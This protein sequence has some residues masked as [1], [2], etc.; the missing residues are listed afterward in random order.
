MITFTHEQK[1]DIAAALMAA[2][3][4]SSFVGS[5]PK[6]ATSVDL[7]PADMTAIKNATWY[8]R[9]KPTIIGDAKWLK[10]A[11]IAGYQKNPDAA[12]HIADTSVK[13]FCFAQMQACQTMSMT[14]MLVD[15]AGIGKTAACKAY[16]ADYENVFYIDC[17]IVS[18]KAAFI[19]ELGKITGAGADGKLNE[20]LDTA[21]YA[22]SQMERPLLIL[23]E[24][25]DIE[26][27]TLLCIKRIYNSLEG[28]CGMYAVGSDGLKTKIKRGVAANKLGFTEF[29]SRFGKKFSV[30]LTGNYEDKISK[31]QAMARDI[32]EANG[33]TDAADLNKIVTAITKDGTVG[34]M[35][36]VKLEVQKLKL[37][38]S[39]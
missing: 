38:K 21:I 34:D 39:A 19:R 36:R 13:R 2:Y 24:A 22:L 26:H 10:I 23:D 9:N 14:A 15:D 5:M 12:W 30:C 6:F 31:L 37:R 8:G 25:G 32:A 11:R 17:S 3:E 27:T 33:V 16:A 20:V 35:R 1:L 29:F 28:L 7:L 4:K 18:N